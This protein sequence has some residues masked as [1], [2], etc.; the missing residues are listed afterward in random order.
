[1]HRKRGVMSSGTVFL[2]WFLITILAIP[3]FRDEIRQ[4]ERRPVNTIGSESLA[5]ADYQFITFMIYFP[6]LVVQLL[7]HVVSDKTP[8]D[9]EYSHLKGEKPSPELKAS[10]VRRMI[11]LWFDPLT[12]RGFRQPL[13]SPDMWDINP[14][15]TSDQMIPI[16]D[17]H[18]KANVAKNEIAY[19]RKMKGKAEDSKFKTG[20]KSTHGNIVPVLFATFG[21]PFYF[22][23]F[24][25]LIIDLLSF[26][27]PQI[28]K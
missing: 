18:W 5:W 2:F 10:F 21:G 11:F 4:F 22:A 26:A 19:N 13:D 23:G 20:P 28:L 14:E 3:Q 16:F 17:R 6:L 1:M 7:A 24:L 8:I 25:K 9:S 27:N 12:W 15:D